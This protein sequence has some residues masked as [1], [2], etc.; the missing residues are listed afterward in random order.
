MLK[1]IS[2][3]FIDLIPTLLDFLFLSE[4]FIADVFFDGFQSIFFF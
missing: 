3:A 2:F 1:D 4:I